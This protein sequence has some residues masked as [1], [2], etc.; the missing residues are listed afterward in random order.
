MQNVGFIG[1]LVFLA[2]VLLFTFKTKS[3]YCGCDMA[4]T[5][6]DSNVFGFYPRLNSSC[7]LNV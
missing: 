6:I 7:K 1:F 4:K 3:G 5:Q 2:L